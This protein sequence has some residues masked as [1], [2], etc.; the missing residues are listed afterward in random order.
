MNESQIRD[1]LIQ[2]LHILNPNYNF[3]DKE[4]YLPSEIGTRSFIDILA[5]DHNGKYIVIEVKKSN[6]TARQAMH[7][8][9][10]YL[11]AIKENLAVK[12]DDIELVIA[13]TE[14]DE[15][16]VPFSSFISNVNIKTKGFH[17]FVENN[18]IFAKEV[19]AN[20]ISEDR[21]LSSIQ[22]ANYYYSTESLEK[23]IEQH[24][25][26]FTKRGIES[27]VLL[28]LKSPEN[29]VELVLESISYFENDILEKIKKEDLKKKVDYQYM[30]YST[31]QL[32]SLKK[33]QE[34]CSKYF[35]SLDMDESIA[36]ILNDDEA[37]SYDKK[38]QFNEL[39]LEQEPFPES[40]FTEI[41]TPAKYNKFIE[42]EG[43]E[44]LEIKKFGA[45]HDNKFLTDDLIEQEI[46]A[47]GTTGE[48]YVS[49]MDIANIA[50]ISRVKREIENCLS[51]NIVWRNH[52]LEIIDSLASESSKIK[53]VRF[54]IY[55]PMN[56]IYS[57][58]LICSEPSGAL[59]IPSYQIAVEL[60]DESRMYIGY[61]DGNF[62]SV[63]IDEILAKFWNSNAFEF[64]LTLTWGG[65]CQNN[66]EICDYIGFEYKTMLVKKKGEERRFY[67]YKNYRFIESEFFNY[68]DNIFMKLSENDSLV[69]EILSF[70]DNYNT[71]NG[72][73]EV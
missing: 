51:D 50:S 4:S 20:V 54:S 26:Y 60:E 18:N 7:E 17:L 70:F 16:L 22:M 38:E 48:R 53:K 41:G 9:F 49:E 25:D 36:E 66:L 24:I 56:I 40:D 1:L 35:S 19:N 32:L 3:L 69:P 64:F 62:Q 31:N 30:I 65:Y 73:W 52:I 34:I 46:K 68:L 6:T 2:N 44:L 8:L 43:W 15:L 37:S 23:G 59:F 29:Y 71:G 63:S 13:S 21:M 61:I 11:E 39:I 27:F 72:M 42:T 57:I 67:N 47:S 12:T 5:C 58:Y 33:Y 10:K 45:L 28:I 55:N 14:W